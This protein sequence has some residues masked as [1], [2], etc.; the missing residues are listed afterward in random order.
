MISVRG[1]YERLLRL[2]LCSVALNVIFWFLN[3]GSVLKMGHPV[4][5]KRSRLSVCS[6]NLILDKKVCLREK[7]LVQDVDN[8][9]LMESNLVSDIFHFLLSQCI[10]TTL[11]CLHAKLYLLDRRF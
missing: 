1:F 6:E 9:T 2:G 10:L 7:C 11:L 8:F 4:G 5:Q 3:S